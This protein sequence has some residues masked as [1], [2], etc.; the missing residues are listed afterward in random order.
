MFLF[1]FATYI[2]LRTQSATVR[3]PWFACQTIDTLA[4][5]ANQ[6]ENWFL[7]VPLL[8][9]LMNVLAHDPVGEFCRRCGVGLETHYTSPDPAAQEATKAEVLKL[10]ASDRVAKGEFLIAT[11][12][13]SVDGEAPPQSS[14]AK[15]TW[16]ATHVLTRR[17]SGHR[18]LRACAFV[19]TT[20]FVEK[21][22]SDPGLL[23]GVNNVVTYTTDDGSTLSGVHVKSESLPPDVKFHKAEVFSEVSTQ[24]FQYN[25]EHKDTVRPGQAEA[26]FQ[27]YTRQRL[28]E[29]PA[30]KASEFG[31]V[32]TWEAWKHLVNEHEAKKARELQELNDRRSS[33]ATQLPMVPAVIS[34]SKLSQPVAPA[35]ASDGASKHAGGSRAVSTGNKSTP[36]KSHGSTSTSAAGS[37]AGVRLTS[38]GPGKALSVASGVSGRVAPSRQSSLVM[39]AAAGDARSGQRKGG[40][41]YE[42]KVLDLTLIL[43]GDTA[44]KSAINPVRTLSVC[45]PLHFRSRTD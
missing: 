11:N 10:L 16:D 43:R 42:R 18:L 38:P 2:R 37:A 22:H 15:R 32:K 36:K 39:I 30:H 40:A 44:K 33:S 6:A 1:C 4:S 23:Q 34:A 7:K 45:L 8:D 28:M 35:K 29:N 31:K 5:R 26:A 27:Y 17:C 12:F 3:K 24:C 41:N 14:D 20:E 21:L 9:D 13:I 19:E 25:L